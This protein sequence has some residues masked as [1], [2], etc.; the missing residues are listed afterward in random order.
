MHTSSQSDSGG[1]RQASAARSHR[2]SRGACRNFVS[3]SGGGPD[4]EVESA[5][6]EGHRCAGSRG[7][8][9]RVETA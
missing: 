4:A 6:L 1:Q 5:E 7:Q 3:L 8:E 2:D 9:H